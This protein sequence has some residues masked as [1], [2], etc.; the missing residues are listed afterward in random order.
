LHF[1]AHGEA[2]LAPEKAARHSALIKS[3][4]LIS[5]DDQQGSR[6][7]SRLP[8]GLRLLY[9]D[10]QIRFLPSSR[11]LLIVGA[12]LVVAIIAASGWA[13]WDQYR[14]AVS[15]YQRNIGTVGTILAEETARD[16]QAVDLALQR[17]AE[18]IAAI[19]GGDDRKFRPLLERHE[20][21]LMLRGLVQD[22]PQADAISIVDADGMLVNFSRAWPLP[23]LDVSDRDYYTH[24]R[25][26]DDTD[27]FVSAPAKSRIT[28]ESTMYLS[29][30]I[31]GPQH[32]F[33]GIVLGAISLRY[34]TDFYSGLG[35]DGGSMTLLRRDG[36]IIARYP[37]TEAML[38][39]L[40]PA[41]SP[42]YD[43]VR[44]GGGLYGSPGYLDGIVRFVSV[45]PLK[46]YPLVVDVTI[47]ELAALADW[48]R[49]AAFIL[50]GAIS[51]VIGFALLFQTLAAQFRQVE[52]SQA[53]LSQRNAELE[54]SRATLETQAAELNQ[55]AAALRSSERRL[56]DFVLTSSDWL[57]EQ[58]V[59]LRFTAI[60]GMMSD[61][62][63]LGKTRREVIDGGVSEEQWAAHQADLEARRPF[64]DFRGEHLAEDGTIRY[65]SVSGLPLFDEVGV[66][67]GY[68]GTGRDITDQV[69][70]EQRRRELEN[71]LHH[72]QR[73]ESLGTLAGGIAHDLN[74]TLVP[75]I[76]LSKLVLKH[77]SPEDEMPA[78]LD[79]VRSS[80]ENI[81]Q[82]GLRARDLVKQILAFSRKETAAKRAIDLA[83][84][85]RQALPMIRAAVPSTIAIDFLATPE[86]PQVHADPSQL[87]QIL[88]NLVT[89]AA[90][91][92]GQSPGR[93]SVELTAA[94]APVGG[95][96][97]LT[98]IHL[99]VTDTG[100]GMDPTTLSRIFEPFFTTKS[101]GEGTGLG[102]A[103]VHGIVA[104]HGGRIAVNSEL[105]RG[106]R[107][108]I[109]LP[110]ERA[111]EAL[112]A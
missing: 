9:G 91:A 95:G 28:G 3:S 19:T 7:Q 48:R 99:A 15:G 31:N 29:R 84:Y 89:N 97:M 90:Q 74:N 18:R 8:E 111:A 32:E 66:F 23:S 63:Y 100:H 54:S 96:T 81:H 44:R 82:A 72:A 98:G 47:S 64:R 103:V 59:D 51:S 78:K 46:H 76:A 73:I 69:R 16:M 52:E 58:N 70:A 61:R 93:I 14:T 106:T 11:R 26:Q 112:E 25:D 38:G 13:M 107:F 41:E 17:T 108:E 94:A 40:M 6:R 67:R 57:W 68:R 105:G 65:I 21:H 30:R 71:Q 88:I 75:V 50:I 79:L 27:I 12:L 85:V 22:M 77:L 36:M 33:L 80:V 35:I 24:F 45:H 39:K 20:V 83:E 55:T 5:P 2:R 102:L 49:Q 87:H 37:D 4:R 34:F 104:S 60:D 56:R 10:Q 62:R 110:G 101:V 53:S 92:I 43:R 109:T 1:L 42:W 86:L